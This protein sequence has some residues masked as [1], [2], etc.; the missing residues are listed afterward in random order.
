MIAFINTPCLKLLN[1][2]LSA[3]VGY[4]PWDHRQGELDD[5]G[6]ICLQTYLR[7]YEPEPVGNAP[8]RSLMGIIIA[9]IFPEPSPKR[10]A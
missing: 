9:E 6:F 1:Y 4:T 5:G 3:L 8:H 2:L 10:Y 7:Y